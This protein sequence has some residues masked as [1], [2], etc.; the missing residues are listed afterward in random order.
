MSNE[1]KL[2]VIRNFMSSEF[3][4]FAIE[5]CEQPDHYRFDLRKDDCHHVILVLN[6]FLDAFDP[7][8]IQMHLTNYNVAMIAS[9]L[10]GFPILVTTSGCIFDRGDTFCPWGR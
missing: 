4:G 3:P 2:D 8:E 9:S 10:I 5:S 7:H 6:E 1:K